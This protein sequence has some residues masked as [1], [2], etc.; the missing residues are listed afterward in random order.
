MSASPCKADCFRDSCHGCI[1]PIKAPVRLVWGYFQINGLGELEARQFN[2]CP[3]GCGKLV[4]NPP[5][6][7]DH[8]ESLQTS[9]QDDEE[10]PPTQRSSGPEKTPVS[11]KGPANRRVSLLASCFVPVATAINL[12]G[13]KGYLT[14][15]RK[16]SL[17]AH[18]IL[19]IVAFLVIAI[20]YYWKR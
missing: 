20:L 11:E 4:A 2:D 18:W 1:R 12:P 9:V 19:R 5:V 15:E 8:H 14:R 17:R 3:C 13:I 16:M 6:G 7:T 10:T